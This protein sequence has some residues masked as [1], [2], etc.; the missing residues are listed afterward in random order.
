[1]T[2]I[3]PTRFGAKGLQGGIENIVS[4]KSLERRIIFY[5]AMGFTLVIVLLWMDEL[6][7]LPHVLFGASGTPVNIVE[8][9]LESG[10]TLLLALVT[11][12][13]TRHLLGRI[14]YLEGFIPIC[15]WCRKVRLNDEWVS[16]EKFIE[17][18]P[19]AQCT[20]G[21]CPEC[22]KRHIDEFIDAYPPQ[23]P[24]RNGDRP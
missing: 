13:V 17:S 5:E 3:R 20:H 16:L 22:R 4:N 15:A 19:D 1:M 18:Q 7:D 2:D 9:A 11:V 12:G 10:F 21:I 23:Q 24:A 14:T 8:S 6:L